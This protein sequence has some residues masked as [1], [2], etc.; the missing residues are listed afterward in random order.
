[1]P[2]ISLETPPASPEILYSL[3]SPGPSYISLGGNDDDLIVSP[4][5]KD[6]T[7]KNKISRSAPD[8]SSGSLRKRVR[9]SRASADT[10]APDSLMQPDFWTG[11]DDPFVDDDQPQDDSGLDGTEPSP[12]DDRKYVD[13]VDSVLE[14][15]TAAFFQIGMNMFVV[16][17]WD[18]KTR[19]S[20]VG[21]SARCLTVRFYF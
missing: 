14:E 4:V 19:R 2:L 10:Q 17:G 7:V 16:N 3:P 9:A 12:G 20:K 21:G 6:R 13:Y 5:K 11:N 18:S 1:M 8:T 15:G